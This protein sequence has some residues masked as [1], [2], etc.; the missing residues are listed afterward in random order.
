MFL[1]SWEKS[2][3]IYFFLIIRLTLPIHKKHEVDQNSVMAES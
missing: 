2:I 1:S 3:S